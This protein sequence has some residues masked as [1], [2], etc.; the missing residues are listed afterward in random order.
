MMIR[1][2]VSVIPSVNVAVSSTTDFLSTPNVSSELLE[3]S[4]GAIR[5]WQAKNRT[6]ILLLP[7]H[8]VAARE[9]ASLISSTPAP[10]VVYLIS[11]DH[12]ASGKSVFTTTD[13]GY[14]TVAG[15]VNGS[16]IK[17][18]QLLDDVPGMRLDSRPFEKEHGISNIVPYIASAWPRVPVV[19]IIVRL[20]ASESDRDALAK[21]LT[22]RLSEDRDALIVSSID[23]SH[24]LPAEVAD[25]HDV[26]ALDV[27]R[28]LSN[29]EAD[30]VEVDSPG[31][32]AVTLKVARDFRLGDVTIHDNTNS[33]RLMKATIAQESTSHVLASFAPGPLKKQQT[34]SLLFVGDM[35][36]DRN[37]ADRIRKSKHAAYAFENIRG[38]ED[39]FFRGQDAVI[40][41]LEGPVTADRLSPV[42]SID[43]AFDPIILKTLNQVGIDA[44]SQANNHAMDQG[45]EGADDS[46]S[47][48]REA[49]II[50]FG[51][52]VVDD[53]TSSLAVIESRGQKIALLGFNVTDNS[54]NLDDAG[55]AI[56]SA[57]S[58]AG[59]VVV[60]MHWGQEY[61]AKPDATQTELAHWFIDQGAD[62][63]IGSH[64]HLVQSVEV[65]NGHP[66]AYSLGN[67]I[68]DQD[69]S[70]ETN[71]GL[72]VGLELS[73]EGSVLRLF[74]IKI[75][76]SQPEL[77]T[78]DERK[79]RLEALAKI[80][81]P[82][83]SD[84]IRAGVIHLLY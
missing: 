9:I 38:T 29:R 28:S 43:F 25:F 41:N 19:P 36:F 32:L 52:E 83:L 35:M 60:F 11:P 12:F 64:P 1:T 61:N 24:Y 40:A 6:R 66:I 17:A 26:L 65:Y 47:R 39:R 74:P 54:I 45:K 51:D 18:K 73:D 69:W 3:Q 48:L 16:S 27:I 50:A 4:F 68:F 2:Q 78:G 10:S 21:A 5:S 49:G 84:Q 14:T 44:V 58:Q 75:T 13:F 56:K 31:A 79:E 8:L 81:N 30:R 63:V 37:V 34:V 77:L 59:R 33:L 62:A 55:I 20:D 7:H 53:A 67:F 71:L 70:D 76:A 23:F 46:K 80:S 82:E 22:E 57:K 72:V 15:T 42:K